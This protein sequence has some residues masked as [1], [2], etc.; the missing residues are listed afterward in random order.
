MDARTAKM[1]ALNAAADMI[2]TS[3]REFLN[4]EYE[5]DDF[6]KIE[7][8]LLVITDSLRERYDRMNERKPVEA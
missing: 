3:L 7:Q 6:D 8:Q 2:D 5:D 4:E 1:I